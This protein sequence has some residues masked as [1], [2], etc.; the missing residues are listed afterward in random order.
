MG[1]DQHRDVPELLHLRQFLP[2]G[3]AQTGIQCRKGFV[4]Q[5]QARLHRQGAGEGNALLLAPGKLLRP[6]RGQVL[7]VKTVEQFRYP[8]APGV[9][10]QANQTE[11]NVVGDAQVREQGIVLR[12]IADAALLGRKV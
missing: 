7:Q 10:G 8:L 5:Q 11:A 12:H 9:C 4:E 2:Q 1:H 3:A 6:P